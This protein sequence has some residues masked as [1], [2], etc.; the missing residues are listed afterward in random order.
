MIQIDI[1]SPPATINRH[2]TPN[3]SHVRQSL[4]KNRTLHSGRAEC[5][6]VGS[7]RGAQIRAGE[8][9]SADRRWPHCSADLCIAQLGWWLVE[10]SWWILMDSLLSPDVTSDLDGHGG[11][12]TCVAWRTHCLLILVLKN[13]LFAQLSGREKHLQCCSRQ[14]VKEPLHALA[15]L[16]WRG[17]KCWDWSQPSATLKLRWP[18][19]MWCRET[20]PFLASNATTRCI[21]WD[22]DSHR[23]FNVKPI[24]PWLWWFQS[25]DSEG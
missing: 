12:E 2:Q 13:V 20:R 22:R 15:C 17:G 16:M 6:G 9:P 14:A 10:L 21:H 25:N 24:A 8:W 3:L 5:L 18:N 11:H 7:W 4:G 23:K 1:S 19:R